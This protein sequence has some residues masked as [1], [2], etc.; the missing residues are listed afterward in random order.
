MNY[1]ARRNKSGQEQ[2]LRDHLLAVADLA[3]RYLEP[4]KVP[5]A[6]LGQLA[7][8]LHDLGKYS[9]E[10]QKK[11][12]GQEELHVHHSHPGA[13]IAAALKQRELQL[14][15]LAHH[16]GLRDASSASYHREESILPDPTECIR[17]MRSDAEGVNISLAL[18]KLDLKNLPSMLATRILLGAL[19]CA[20]WEDSMRFDGEGYPRPPEA[21]W[22]HVLLLLHQY[23]SNLKPSTDD[24]VN[25]ARQKVW[26]YAGALAQQNPGICTLSAPTGTGKTLAMLRFALEHAIKHN[27]RRI[28]IATPFLSITDQWEEL[29]NKLIDEYLESGDD[30]KTS[31][32]VLVDHSLVDSSEDEDSLDYRA[33]NYY[34]AWFHPII[35]T[36]FNQ[37]LES[38]FERQCSSLR[39]LPQL[40]RSV[41]MLDEFHTVPTELMEYTLRALRYV[42]EWGHSSILLAS[43][44]P[45]EPGVVSNDYQI[46]SQDEPL[47][48]SIL[49]APP[50]AT[51]R[52]RRTFHTI[53]DLQPI[54]INELQETVTTKLNHGPVCVVLN[55]T[56]DAATLA[57]FLYVQG[58]D[59]LHLSTRMCPKHREKRLK[60]IREKLDNGE[61][62]VL[63]ATQCIEAGIDLDFPVLFRALAP[64]T[65]IVQAAGRC[66]RHGK[67]PTG[68]VYLFTLDTDGSELER[69]KYLSSFY[70]QGA[71]SVYNNIKEAKI[72]IQQLESID[73]LMGYQRL[74]RRSPDRGVLT[75]IG[76]YDFNGVRDSYQLIQRKPTV[77]IIIPKYAGGIQAVDINPKQVHEFR[78]AMVDVFIKDGSNLLSYCEPVPRVDRVYVLLEGSLYDDLI[79]L[80]PKAAAFLVV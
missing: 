16:G 24:E 8:L 56:E 46:L 33:R 68:D 55:F 44:T 73:T 60:E 48:S 61:R 35:V 12:H 78:K 14:A 15:I 45:P 10:F 22:K 27:L 40:A 58:I 69:L 37:L 51:L 2:L 26:D 77:S 7:G 64:L 38:L 72:D 31:H 6:E 34:K 70:R 43:A 62:F 49:N 4:W 17:T 1:I 41:I 36:T 76:E 59:V 65:S 13:E 63:V 71:L 5:S 75:G 20:D 66:N 54:T 42:S 52:P 11:I 57:S 25:E 3:R 28:I 47:D 39:K 53:N 18:P 50:V 80:D 21:D 9:E 29:I 23:R 67:L 19:V 30:K 79:G 32:F 74:V